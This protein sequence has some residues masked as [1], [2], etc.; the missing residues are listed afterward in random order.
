MAKTKKPK[1]STQDAP[2][3]PPGGSTNPPPPRYEISK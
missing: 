2:S 1:V 3:G